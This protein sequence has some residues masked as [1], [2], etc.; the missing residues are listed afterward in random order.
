MPRGARQHLKQTI[1]QEVSRT[2]RQAGGDPRC[3]AERYR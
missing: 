3:Y 2:V 1:V